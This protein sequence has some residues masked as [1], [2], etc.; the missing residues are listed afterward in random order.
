MVWGPTEV[1]TKSGAKGCSPE[2]GEETA[3]K[4]G[5]VT[6]VDDRRRIHIRG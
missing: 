3:G 1:G 6:T 2:R 4:I 5:G